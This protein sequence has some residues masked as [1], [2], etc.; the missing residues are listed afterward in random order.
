MSST[1]PL[2]FDNAGG[3]GYDGRKGRSLELCEE[4]TGD[5]GDD[6]SEETRPSSEELLRL[7]LKC[8]PSTKNVCFALDHE[9]AS[10]AEC[11]VPVWAHALY[12]LV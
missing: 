3:A 4:G 6:A 2:I 10:C 9:R 7:S 11:W 1:S 8:A 5:I 12:A